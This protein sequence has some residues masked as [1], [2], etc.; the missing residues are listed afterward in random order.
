MMNQSNRARLVLML[1][2][3]GS[4]SIG[5]KP[6]TTQT[7][8]GAVTD[9]VVQ[10]NNVSSPLAS[11]AINPLLKTAIDDAEQTAATIKNRARAEAEAEAG[12]IIAQAQM[13][14]QQ[15]KDNAETAAQKQTDD[16]VATAQRK[17]EII[18]VEAKQKA[19]QF[20]IAASEEI[21]KE[22]SGEYKRVYARLSASLQ[23][24]MNEAQRINTELAGRTASL[25]ESKSFVLKEHRTA[26]LGSSPETPS[27]VE[28][29]PV[30][31][32][33]NPEAVKKPEKKLARRQREG[34]ET[35]ARRFLKL[36]GKISW[37]KTREAAPLVEE[38]PKLEV[39]PKI[40]DIMREKLDISQFERD[41]PMPE[42]TEAPLAENKATEE[43][44][45]KG[46]VSVTSE[47]KDKRVRPEPS[48]I[49]LDNEALYTGEVELVIAPPVELKLVSKL[50]NYLQTVAELRILYTRGSWDRGTT[51]MV[52]LD[53]PLPL[54]GV[55]AA[56]PEVE[57]IPE[58]LERDEMSAGKAGPLLRGGEKRNRGIKLSLEEKPSA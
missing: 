19:L 24:L 21:E 50:Y 30:T 7:P 56:T 47:E 58:L 51:I 31:I 15:I 33:L 18:E 41:T 23:D 42:P 32:E 28:A 27:P 54:I 9:G 1:K 3:L 2:R 55:L 5:G 10:P 36:G 20:L 40:E 6:K 43:P 4:L 34:L 49:I 29:T 13:E 26:L 38:A 52:V 12:R 35:R 17:A 53:K 45:K 16:I 8:D 39:T 46:P 44:P 48:R 57:V 25:W 11:D 14:A 22:I 37:R